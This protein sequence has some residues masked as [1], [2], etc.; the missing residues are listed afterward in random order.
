MRSICIGTVL[1]LSLATSLAVNLREAKTLSALREIDADPAGHDVLA[2]LREAAA[3]DPRVELNV[4][5]QKVRAHIEADRKNEEELDKETAENCRHLLANLEDQVQTYEK[6]VSDANSTVISTSKEREEVQNEID[7]GRERQQELHKNFKDEKKRLKA[8]KKERKETIDQLQETISAVDEAQR[9]LGK[10]GDLKAAVAS[11]EKALNVA[12]SV[13]AANISCIRPSLESKERKAISAA[14]TELRNSLSNQLSV[15]QS[16][17]SDLTTLNSIKAEQADVGNKLVSLTRR[18]ELIVRERSEAQ[19]SLSRYLGIL[20]GTQESLC[21]TRQ[22]CNQEDL[23]TNREGR[24]NATEAAL[25]KIEEIV[26]KSP[27]L[28][29]R[30]LIQ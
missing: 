5:V 6:L 17:N 20:Q 12:Q 27:S 9:Q 8:E 21:I 23:R 7:A 2:Q 11:A 26:E 13:N 15:L 25:N 3:G 29:Q 19:E 10:T 1:L 16:R 24:Y 30:Y 14:L 18:L 4:T 28:I 22:E